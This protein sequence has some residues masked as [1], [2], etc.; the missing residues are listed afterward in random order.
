MSSSGRYSAPVPGW[1]GAIQSI[2]S[3]FQGVKQA[4]RRLS[5]VPGRRPGPRRPER[6]APGDVDGLPGDEGRELRGEEEGSPGDVLR[7]ADPAEGDRLAELGHGGGGML[8]GGG[9]GGG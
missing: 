8:G 3:P 1:E 2:E 6:Q 5:G 9:E 4:F 7:R